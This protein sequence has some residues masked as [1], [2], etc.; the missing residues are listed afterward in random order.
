MRRFT[1]VPIL[2]IILAGAQTRAGDRLGPA[3]LGSRTVSFTYEARVTP[4]EGTRE[5]DLWMPLP[6][7][8]D[9]AV[10]A[11][12][13]RGSAEPTVVRLP[14]SGDRAAY[15]RVANPAGPVTLTQTA[16]VARR[17][18]RAVASTS[19]AR[20]ED[21][22]AAAY[23][24]ELGASQAVQINDDIRAIAA[25][26]TK[27]KDSVAAKARA[28][29][30]WVHGHMQYDK[31]V[32]G[33]GLGDIPYCL[34]VGKGN[35]TDFHTLFIALARASGIP[36]RWN[37]GFP[38]AYGDGRAAG[39]APQQVA[40]YHCWAEFY[41]PGA[42]W[43]PVDVSEARKHPELRDYFFGGLSGN[44]VLFTRGRDLALAADG[45]GKR[46][47]YFIHPVARADERDVPG[48]EWTFRYVDVAAVAAGASDPLAAR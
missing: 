19:R 9:Q 32:P 42:G 39:G 15:L 22:D 44:R 46:L 17:E 14:G 43:V 48:V 37:M 4:P 30:D 13:L 29:Y 38:L 18:V 41:A 10:L 7:E 20:L 3:D 25:R 24:A 23:A 34:K 21:V 33:W 8:E 31:S 26:E 12:S 45:S 35:C 1:I 36:A 2:A 40:G 47:N 11:L 27:G 6:R 16:T 28:L 5:L